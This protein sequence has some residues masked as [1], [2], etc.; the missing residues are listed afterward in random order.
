MTFRQD[1]KRRNNRRRGAGASS[2]ELVFGLMLLVPVALVLLDLGFIM[3]SV[4]S[5][6]SLC[7]EA[8]RAAAAT[9]PKDAEKI[10]E[11]IVSKANTTGGT[12][13]V[14]SLAGKPEL[15][16]LKVPPAEQGG[17]V[18]G[19]V[20]THTSVEV[21]PMFLV[22]I[23]YGGKPINFVTQKTFPYTYVMQPA[24]KKEPTNKSTSASSDD[25]DEEEE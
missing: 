6:D 17:L 2:V 5:N 10:A 4:F 11:Q 12:H 8:C 24:P 21:K 13:T 20:T 9:D 18:E 3:M 15:T 14:Y 1:S 7:R 25:A 16:G 22:G 19:S 23:F